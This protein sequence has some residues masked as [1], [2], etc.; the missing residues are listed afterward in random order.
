MT[1]LGTRYK[2]VW[3]KK[4]T[5]SRIK[6][7]DIDGIQDTLPQNIPPWHILKMAKKEKMAE[8]GIAF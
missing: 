2:S 6:G 8:A 3:D 7:K 4:N 5:A 1:C